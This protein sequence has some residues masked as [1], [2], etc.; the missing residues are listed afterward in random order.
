MSDD[1]FY[2]PAMGR[3]CHEVRKMAKG[4]PEDYVTML[5]NALL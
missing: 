1:W 2:H 3:T 4:L 5:G